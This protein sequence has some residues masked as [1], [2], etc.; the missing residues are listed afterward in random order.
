[1]SFNLIWAAAIPAKV[2]RVRRSPEAARGEIIRAA[3]EAL[4]EVPFSALTVD[5]VMGRTSMTRSSFYHYF[6]GLDEIAVGLLDQIERDIRAS[7]DAWLKG[8]TAE[9]DYRAAT[10]VHFEQMFATIQSHRAAHVAVAQAASG[11]RAVYQ[12]W[13]RRVIGYFVDLT[14]EFIRRQVALGRSRVAEPDRIAQALILMNNAVVNDSLSKE[15]PDAAAELA[16]TIAV[17]WNS[18][19]YGQ[20]DGKIV[21]RGESG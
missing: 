11:N 7:V 9:Q 5:I 14:A 17:I 12:E 4:T 18:T 6:S 20:R 1:M 19:I 16:E 3:E 13:Q 8:E 10:A 21:Q 15:V 2:Q